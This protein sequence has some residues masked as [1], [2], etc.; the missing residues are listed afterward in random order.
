MLLLL[1]LHG[2]ASGD[3]LPPFIELRVMTD[4][5]NSPN[6]LL[7]SLNLVIYFLQSWLVSDLALHLFDMNQ[8]LWFGLWLFEI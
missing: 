8:K 4:L 1:S 6:G 7:F 2:F 3:V 5:H